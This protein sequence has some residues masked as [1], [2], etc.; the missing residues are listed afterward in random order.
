MGWPLSGDEPVFCKVAAERVDNLC[1]LAHQQVSCSKHNAAGLGILAFNRY[2]PHR[3][4]L[5]GLAYCF[6]IGHVT[7][8]SLD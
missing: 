7:F 5:R 1:S 2:K 4:A 6:R 3:R 8:L